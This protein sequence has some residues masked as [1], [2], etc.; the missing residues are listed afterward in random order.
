MEFVE[1]LAFVALRNP[2]NSIN[3]MNAIKALNALWSLREI[4][5]F[6]YHAR[7]RWSLEN[8]ECAE[9]GI[10]AMSHELNLSGFERESEIDIR[11]LFSLLPIGDPEFQLL[12][13]GHPE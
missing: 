12:P 5:A 3:A 1:L 7:S 9:K 2:I 10:F 4:K 11:E 13:S 8:A 6:V